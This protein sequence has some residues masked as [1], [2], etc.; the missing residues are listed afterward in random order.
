MTR[1]T[2]VA[3]IIISLYCF[4]CKLPTKPV[5][6]IPNDIPT[7]D[8]GMAFVEPGSDYIL[9]WGS[10]LTPTG[11]LPQGQILI[12]PDGIIQYVGSDASGEPGA[13]GAT[14]IIAAYG[15]A[16]PGLIDSLHHLNWA[17]HEPVSLPSDNAVYD[18][19]HRHEW[20]LGINGKEKLSFDRG[21]A[22][23]TSQWGEIR[24]VMN[25]V[26]SVVGF[27]TTSDGG[28][29]RNL[30]LFSGL[31]DL[32]LD[33]SVKNSTFPLG[34][35]VGPLTLDP[36][37]YNPIS[38]SE[39]D[40]D[41]ALIA[42][43]A[44]GT[45]AE[46]NTEFQAIAT[47][48]P[49]P[50][51]LSYK[52]VIGPGIGLNTDDL[53]TMS[54]E[55]TSLLWTPRSDLYLYGHTAP[56]TTMRALGGNIVLGSN[57]LPTGSSSVWREMIAAREFNKT[58]LNSTFSDREIIDMVTIN[59]ASALQ[60]SDKIGSIAQGLVADIVI[61]DTRSQ[62]GTDALF[63]AEPSRIGLVL[64][65]GRPLYGDDVII[66][67]LASSLSDFETVAV[68]GTEDGIIKKIAVPGEF[69]TTIAAIET[70]L[71]S[72]FGL[73][74]WRSGDEPP[75]APR[76][77]T[78]P[79]AP[80]AGD[81]D[82]D[83]VADASDNAPLIYNPPRPM[84]GGVQQDDDGDGIGDVADPTPFGDFATPNAPTSLVASDGMAQ[85][86]IELDWASSPGANVYFISRS[87]QASGPFTQIGTSTS[88][89]YADTDV[90]P[91]ENHY[92]IIEA[93]VVV[94]GTRS[95]PSNVAHGITLSSISISQIR[96]GNVT[97]RIFIE[98]VIVTAV[99]PT[100][101]FVQD[102]GGGANSGITVYLGSAP[103]VA[104]GD[105]LAIDGV[106]AEYY[107]DLQLQNGTTDLVTTV[108]GTGF[109]PSATVL[110]SSPAD[111]ETYEGALI[112]VSSLTVGVPSDGAATTS[113]TGLNI[114]DYLYD[115]DNVY[116]SGGTFSS[117]V[118]VITYEPDKY[119]LQPRSI[120][121][122]TPDLLAVDLLESIGPS[123]SYIWEGE[124]RS[125][126]PEV[127]AVS[128]KSICPEDI[129]VIISSSDAGLIVGNVIIPAGNLSAVVP[130]EA[131]TA[132]A[133]PYTI[134]ASLNSTDLTAEVRVVGATETPSL[135]SLT[136]DSASVATNDTVELTVELDLPA[137]TGGT[138][139]N[140]SVSGN[141][142]TPT[143]VTVLHEELTVSFIFTASSAS[144]DTVTATLGL[145]SDSATIDVIESSGSILVINEVDYDTP[146]TDSAEFIEIF[147]PGT[148]DVDLSDKAVVLVNG[149]DSN[150]ASR[151]S[152]S[153]TLAAGDYLLLAGTGVTVPSGVTAISLLDN[154]VQNGAPDGVVLFDTT[155]FEI[156]DAI[157]YEGSITTATI[158]GDPGYYD[159]VEGTATSAEDNN[160]TVTSIIRWPNGLDTDN[161]ADDWTET[162]TP[163][164]G[165]ANSL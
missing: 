64:R 124:T 142:S 61:V 1:L 164:P 3:L 154:S 110:A 56:V 11:I 109:E 83:G 38:W 24:L 71:G 33:T 22:P 14:R 116:P 118:G 123:L 21:L 42:I 96:T 8:K 31:D 155:N 29:V 129:T 106:L 70:A 17:Q 13:D 68:P 78:L 151:Y 114:A 46:A 58:Y 67:S 135:V 103:S 52:S 50:K 153:G 163:T 128:L 152:L 112:S 20:R 79:S 93:A 77:T 89:T 69:G 100:K 157:S 131:V 162:T 55:G 159:L 101:Y 49:S 115:Y 158:I 156:M 117:V 7:P 94:S 165:A 75:A 28:M 113:Y 44:E 15:L 90:G 136:P 143:T 92:Y 43:I 126:F 102:T 36:T 5:S 99:G 125:T 66:D 53:M 80:T 133:S 84:D 12:D 140:L 85:F 65:A 16:I 108:N 18:Y 145:D 107:G 39:T 137:P 105:R 27:T 76:R 32:G 111:W 104:V 98:D 139:V 57:W 88:N 34:D 130:L 2:L 121:D 25:G 30:D 40:P 87:D 6:G 160:D 4:G 74:G 19:D 119:R 81:I 54:S 144:S 72:P 62:T 97:G 148:T 10:V 47:T 147:N 63:A 134:T 161:A 59:P 141:G 51:L 60:L 95:A 127:L 150:E 48:S 91:D 86:A 73:F 37:A 120:D 26:T 132:S 9:Y 122:M 138:A 23:Q 146:G 35:I 45:I 149:S 82:G 41:L